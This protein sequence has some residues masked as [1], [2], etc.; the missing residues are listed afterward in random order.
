MK[1]TLIA[2]TLIF[3]GAAS[4]ASA[5]LVGDSLTLTH[6]FPDLSSTYE[7]H[8]VVGAAGTSDLVNMLGLYTVDVE[9]S[10][11]SADMVMGDVYH[12]PDAWWWTESSFNG[13]VITGID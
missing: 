11:I 5:W 10:S 8:N 13:L 4:S 12:S 1:N 6:Y 3:A 7:S 9:G 2:C